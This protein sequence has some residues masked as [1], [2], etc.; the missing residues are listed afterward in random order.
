MDD[1]SAAIG[2]SVLNVACVTETAVPV[3]LVTVSTWASSCLA[4]AWIR[5]VPRPD[6]PPSRRT[7]GL[8]MPLSET[9]SFQSGPA[10]RYETRIAAP[11]LVSWERVL[12]GVHHQFGD[13]QPDAD[14]IAGRGGARSDSTV[15]EMAGCRRSS[16]APGFRRVW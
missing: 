16:I 15:S 11:G 2:G 12:Q 5:L 4:S 1:V 3:D 14:R 9:V 10:T 6:L 8:P 13:D 7:S